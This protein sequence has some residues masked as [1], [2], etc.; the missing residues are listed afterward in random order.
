MLVESST[1]AGMDAVLLPVSSLGTDGSQF[2]GSWFAAGL[3]VGFVALACEAV[4]GWV[5]YSR[6][7]RSVLLTP[8]PPRLKALVHDV[9]PWLVLPV[10]SVQPLAM[11]AMRYEVAAA[12]GANSLSGILST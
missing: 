10:G 8:E 11:P 4:A 12:S 5:G 6:V 3:R 9:S 7:A 1:Y 2:A